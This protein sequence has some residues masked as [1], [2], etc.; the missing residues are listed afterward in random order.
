MYV[1]PHQH[2]MQNTKH[3]FSVPQATTCV[4]IRNWNRMQPKTYHTVH[5]FHDIKHVSNTL[6]LFFYFYK[7]GNGIIQNC[8]SSLLLTSKNKMTQH[9]FITVNLNQY[10]TC[11]ATTQTEIFSLLKHRD[12]VKLI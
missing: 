12:H 11:H 8:N 9:L 3:F 4:K 7:N 5:Y 1:V 2:S 6:Y 10:T